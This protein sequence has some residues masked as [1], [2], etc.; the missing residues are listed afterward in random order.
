MKY[1]FA[2]VLVI[3]IISCKSEK[4]K[5]PETHNPSEFITQDLYNEKAIELY[6]TATEN[7]NYG[8]FDL[9]KELLDRAFEIEKS[10]IILN[11]LGTIAIA[12]KKFDDAVS[13]FDQSITLGS[14]YLPSYINKARSLTLL[15][16]YETA[17]YT[18]NELITLSDSDYWIAYAN[19]Y[20]AYIYLN[21]QFD[22]ERALDCIKKAEILEKESELV[23][24]YKGLKS[25]IKKNCG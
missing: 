23:H 17:E 11:E 22:C 10:P 5:I 21:G 2:I 18:L 20:L 12:E 15:S 19:L 13:I 24:Q 1:T 7:Y 9:A 6:L 8:N 3:L 25:D 4:D 14:T 16:Q